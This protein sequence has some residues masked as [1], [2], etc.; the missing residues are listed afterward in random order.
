MLTDP[1]IDIGQPLSIGAYIQRKRTTIC[2]DTGA[3]VNAINPNYMKRKN[4]IP[5]TVKILSKPIQIQVRNSQ[6]MSISEVALLSLSSGEMQADIWFLIINE[7]P[8]DAL[9]GRPSVERV[10]ISWLG[11]KVMWE[12]EELPSNELSM[13]SKS[14]NYINPETLPPVHKVAAQSKICLGPRQ[15]R[16][17]EV[18]TIRKPWGTQAYLNPTLRRKG[19][20]ILVPGLVDVSDDET[21]MAII[22]NP[23]T[24]KQYIPSGKKVG[25]IY[26]ITKDDE[27]NTELFEL[28]GKSLVDFDK[29][30]LAKDLKEKKKSQKINWEKTREVVNDFFSNHKRKRKKKNITLN[31][32]DVMDKNINWN[33]LCQEIN[34]KAEEAESERLN[35]SDSEKL[36]KLSGCRETAYEGKTNDV[37]AKKQKE[38]K[39]Q[40]GTTEKTRGTK[41]QKKSKRNK[42]KSKEML[43]Q[44]QKQQKRR[45]KPRALDP[46]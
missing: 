10:G 42:E 30:L 11:N 20:L 13:S 36:D 29:N 27:N 24:R 19:R 15:M 23:T 16:V 43:L 45:R 7:L 26:Y 9:V 35:T 12:D 3:G 2:L 41:M 6:K 5:K 37:G 25:E 32:L 44:S 8:M 22:T 18:K 40:R 38:Q 28:P 34:K 39:E 1:T 31:I 14:L 4:I 33:R 21:F 17:V 46:I